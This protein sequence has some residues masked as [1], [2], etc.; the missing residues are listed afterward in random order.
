[1]RY[2]I[3]VVPF[4]KYAE[5]EPVI[6]L[7]VAAEE[8]GWE[9]LAMWDHGHFPGGV[10]DPWVTFAAVASRTTKL[11]LVTD[12]VPVPRYRPHLLAR[13]VHALDA[14]SGG[15]VTLGVGLGQ[16]WDLDAVGDH[17]DDVARA[18]M[19]DE[20]IDLVVRWCNGE[21]V[22]HAG[23]YFRSDG[24]HVASAP[25]QRPRVPVWVGGTSRP[26]LRR[27]ARWDGWIVPTIGE[28][29][30]MTFGPERLAE[31]IAYLHEQGAAPGFDVAVNGATAPREVGITAE[32]IDAGATWWLESLF[33]LRATHE[34]LLARVG[35]G[36]PV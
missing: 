2:G 30:S 21:T 6:E 16:A 32:Y 14:L 25:T 3:E 26:A 29:L 15:R 35:A 4:G 20:A 34:E 11:R 23:A 5:P 24:A 13:S 27:A 9:A 22:E 7:A 31:G 1:M 36:P 17:H 8:A 10:A 33:E 18:A 19:A 12:V 28:D